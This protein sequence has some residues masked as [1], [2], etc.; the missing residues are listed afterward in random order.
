MNAW[1]LILIGK[2]SNSFYPSGLDCPS[3]RQYPLRFLR[4][5]RM[6]SPVVLEV[7]FRFLKAFKFDRPFEIRMPLISDTDETHSALPS[8]STIRYRIIHRAQNHLSICPMLMKGY[9]QS[10]INY[11]SSTHLPQYMERTYTPSPKI[12]LH[13]SCYPNIG[14]KALRSQNINSISSL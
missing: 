8:L 10:H 6:E 5:F 13:I 4:S 12:L 1:S 14:S 2:F 3:S 7:S 11:V 9:T